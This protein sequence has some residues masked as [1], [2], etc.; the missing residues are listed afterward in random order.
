[1]RGANFTVDLDDLVEKWK[2]MVEYAINTLNPSR[3]SYSKIGYKL[4]NISIKRNWPLSLIVAE[5]LFTLFFVEACQK[6][7]LSYR[8]QF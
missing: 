5:L 7:F 2:A 6:V 8:P 1:M 3:T 4:F